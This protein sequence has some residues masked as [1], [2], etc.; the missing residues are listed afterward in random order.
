MAITWYPTKINGTTILWLSFVHGK[1]W[2]KG[3][4]I[5]GFILL[6]INNKF[7]NTCSHNMTINIEHQQTNK[8][9]N[10]LQTVVLL[11]LSLDVD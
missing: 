5:L 1:S 11:Y 2:V 8:L 6:T 3:T 9:I 10:I 4:L 7:V